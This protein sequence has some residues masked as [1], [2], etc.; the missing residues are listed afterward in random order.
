MARSLWKGAVSFGLLNIP[1]ELMSAS[2]EKR[3]S[4]H[5]LDKRD[6]SPIGYKQY[7]KVTGKEL[8][9]KNI[10]KG[11][12]YEKNQYV[13][14]EEKDFVK[15]NPKATQTIDIEDFI[16][17]EDLDF[18]LFEKPYYLVPGKNGEK[19]YVLLRKVLEQTKKVAIAKFILHN[20]QHLAAIIPKGDYL[21]LEVLRFAHEINEVHEVDLLNHADLNRVKVSA[22]ELKLAQD[23]V[24]GMTAEWKP[25]QYK[26]TYQDE[27]LKYIKN[28]IKR[29][30][31]EF[32]E[33]IEK[34]EVTNTNL[35]DLM[36]LLTKSLETKKTKP[37]SPRVHA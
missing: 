18:L 13:L 9:K 24:A 12:E 28:K 30:D 17:L 32:S 21:I 16:E 26:N 11:Y 33:R 27:L 36:P 4:F 15:A 35:V 2:Q 31:V 10:I 8:D 3:L 7:N 23:L 5:L 6:N 25:E 22:K 14:L 19:G 20:S 1:I 34:E 29:G 37:R